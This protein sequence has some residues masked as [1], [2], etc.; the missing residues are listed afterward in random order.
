MVWDEPQRMS[1]KSTQL[2][3][4]DI[5][6]SQDGWVA[7]T[8]SVQARIEPE[9]EEAMLDEKQEILEESPRLEI[10]NIADD[11]IVEFMEH[12]PESTNVKPL[13]VNGLLN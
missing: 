11:P 1:V 13:E 8:Y 9:R 12:I 10:G 6:G 7:E 4:K 5:V 3:V 2:A